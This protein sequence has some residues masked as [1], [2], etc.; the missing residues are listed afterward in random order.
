MTTL[1]EL[2]ERLQKIEALLFPDKAKCEYWTYEELRDIIDKTDLTPDMDNQGLVDVGPELTS[3][4]VRLDNLGHTDAHH[5]E[6]T[7]EERLNMLEST[8]QILE[9]AHLGHTN[10]DA[11]EFKSMH[12]FEPWQIK[13]DLL[14]RMEGMQK[15]LDRILL[16]LKDKE[17]SVSAEDFLQMR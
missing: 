12:G 15:K 6:Q 16:L 10:S 2:N 5:G 17:Y 9:G 14:Q 3:L 1:S 8:I 7:L 13:G 11:G 4:Q